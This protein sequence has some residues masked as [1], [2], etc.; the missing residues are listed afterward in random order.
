LIRAKKRIDVEAKLP[1]TTAPLWFSSARRLMRTVLCYGDSNTWGTAVV[2]RPDG[3]YAPDE[4][5]PGAARAAL[6]PEWLMIEEGLPGRTTVH[7]DPVEG[8][9]RNGRSYL[10][11]CLQSHRPLDVV[12]I[13]LGTN[14]LKARF[15]S[16]AFDIAEGVGALVNIVRTAG[17][18]RSEGVPAIIA[19]AP[20][21]ILK[22]L[23]DHAD[24][25]AGGHEKS[26]GLAKHFRAMAKRERV[27]FFDAGS[28]IKSSKVDGFHLEPEAHARLGRA[29]A[30]EIAKAAR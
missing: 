24:M 17:A 11:P 4:R 12:V 26:L 1:H 3:R 19:V 8:A 28:A 7:D 18:G 15:N 29:L 2:P 10:L 23:P 27:G 20:P 9:E 30:A 6:G 13:M 22:R 21:P 14:D 16:S 25:F 5:W